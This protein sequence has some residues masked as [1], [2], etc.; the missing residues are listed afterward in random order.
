M[1]CCCNDTLIFLIKFSTRL[2][3]TL[4]V[5]GPIIIVFLI[6]NIVPD[7][8][9]SNNGVPQPG[10]QTSDIPIMV[11][12]LSTYNFIITDLSTNK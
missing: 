1:K 5:E 9:Y 6:Y 3:K 4:I 7:F 10:L 2:K 11:K 12:P 8:F